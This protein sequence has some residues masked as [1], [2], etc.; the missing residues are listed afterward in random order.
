MVKGDHIEDH[1]DRDRQH[2][3]DEHV[4]AE[5]AAPGRQFVIDALDLERQGH[6]HRDRAGCNH[7]QPDAIIL[8]DKPQER[9][10]DRRDDAGQAN[11]AH[12]EVQQCL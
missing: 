2:D 8:Q 5:R 12:Q 6:G 3:L 4:E 7:E 9:A 11:E 1:H 10:D